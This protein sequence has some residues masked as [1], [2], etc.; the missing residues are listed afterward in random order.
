[1]QWMWKFQHADGQR[2]IDE[3]HVPLGRAVRLT[4][5]SEDVIHSLFVPAFR[6]KQDVLPGRYT[7]T[8]FNATKPGTYHLFCAEYCGT[9]HSGM[10]G[11]VVVME[12]TQY[13]SWLGAGVVEG[14]VASAG[15]KLFQDLGCS[16]CHTG[17]AQARGPSLQGLFG[18]PVTLEG[19]GTAV[20][21][22]SYIRESVIDPRAKIVAGHLPTPPG[23]GNFLLRLRIG[24]RDVAFP[25]LNLAS[26][27]IYMAG[28]AFISTVVVTGGV[29]TGWTFYTP[30]STMSSTSHV[31]PTALGIFIVGFSSILTGL[32]FID[33]IHRMR[34]PE[35]TWFRLPLFV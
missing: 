15:E 29:D 16:T 3:L 27:Y 2:E 13:E 34:A 30:Y 32:N 7:T 24:G 22:E 23:L 31:I 9:V 4:M 12:P 26:W 14:S 6:V 35:L 17:E 1:K 25:R 18:R 5:T 33:T 20:V 8:W 28:A 11:H 19:G 21:D 10:I